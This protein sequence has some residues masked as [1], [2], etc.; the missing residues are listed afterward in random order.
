MLKIYWWN[1]GS[2]RLDYQGD[3]NGFFEAKGI[4]YRSWK[5]QKTW[6]SHNLEHHEFAM[7]VSNSKLSLTTI[8]Q[9]HESASLEAIKLFLTI[10]GD[11]ALI[12]TSS[13]Q[14]KI[15]WR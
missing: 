12:V 14:Y 9:T 6:N 15:N 5:L 2:K 3:I 10:L 8:G 7:A 1:M 11:K 13:N 4:K